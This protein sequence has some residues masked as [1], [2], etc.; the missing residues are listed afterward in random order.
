M[1]TY[2]TANEAKYAIGV[3]LGGTKILAAVVDQNGHVL[4]DVEVATA[5]SGD[6]GEVYRQIVS[7]VQNLREDFPEPLGLGVGA[8]GPLDL[9]EGVIWSMPN[10][11]GTNIHLSRQLESDLGLTVRL[12]NDAN[13]A[14]LAE[15]RFSATR[16]AIENAV[17]LALGTGVGGAILA[18]SQIVHGHLGAAGELGHLKVEEPGLECGCSRFGCL[19]TV[20]SGPGILKIATLSGVAA[21]STRDLIARWRAEPRLNCPVRKRFV[22]ALSLAIGVQINS[23]NPSHIFIAGGFGLAAFES[24]HRE[25]FESLKSLCFAKALATTTILPARSGQFSG[26]MGAASAFF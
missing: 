15:V 6:F 16:S 25:V 14:L 17:L 3:D 12:E 22:R 20:A 7:L 5:R 26:V 23:F 4:T 24:F 11:P 19:E 8:P 9:K 2:E 10:L 21:D 1:N 18:N 13:A